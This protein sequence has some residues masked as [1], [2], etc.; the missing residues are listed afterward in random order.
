MSI[1][2][3]KFRNHKVNPETEILFI[4]TFNPDL[5]DEVDFFYGRSR[6]FL[7]HLLPQC[8]GLEPLK[9][10]PLLSKQ[11]FMA[12]Y[13]IDFADLIHSLEIPEGEERIVD[14]TFIDSHVKEWK[15]IIELIDTLPNLKAVYFTRKT[16]NGI[17]NMR[18][19]VNLIADHCRQKGIRLCKLE[20]P[21]RHYSPEKLQQWI[22]T[23][24]L[25]T[26]CLKP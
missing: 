25:Q 14:D 5:P 9:D 2:L 13:K 20:T 12:G 10:A 18:I 19:Q 6:S 1:I 17:P 23:I 16:F 4:G 7:W 15:N 24:V 3:H 21:A 8:W 22:D 26:T 11:E